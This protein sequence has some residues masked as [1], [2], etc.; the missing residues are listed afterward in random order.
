[1]IRSELG[2]NVPEEHGTELVGGLQLCPLLHSPRSLVNSPLDRARAHLPNEKVAMVQ[3]QEDESLPLGKNR[4][5]S[6]FVTAVGR[7]Q[8][9]S[10]KS[11]LHTTCQ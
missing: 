4:T 8:G 9:L 3:H 2:Q 7:A 11:T 1:M 10:I 5:E 6:G